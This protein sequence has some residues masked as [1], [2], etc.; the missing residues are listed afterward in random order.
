MCIKAAR[1]RQQGIVALEQQPAH[2][3]DPFLK[4][5]LTLALDGIEVSEIRQIMGIEINMIGARLRSRGEGTR[6]AG[7]YAPHHRHHWRR[8]R[9]ESW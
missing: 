6:D 3:Q 2:I 8:T 4:N 5:A 7:G 1:A 9:G